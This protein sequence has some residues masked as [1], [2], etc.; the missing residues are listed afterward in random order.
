MFI[1]V[2]IKITELVAWLVSFNCYEAFDFVLNP[3]AHVSMPGVADLN[4][5]ISTLFV[6]DCL[7]YMEK[8]YN[9]Y[10]FWIV[11]RYSLKKRCHIVYKS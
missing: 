4:L 7:V 6:L 11:K 10:Y 1:V 8:K 9:N 3:F 5:V 2:M